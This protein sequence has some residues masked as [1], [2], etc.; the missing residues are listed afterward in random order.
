M[1]WIAF[2]LGLIIGCSLGVLLAGICA[3]AH[4]EIDEIERWAKIQ[5]E[6]GV[7]DENV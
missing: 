2:S 5:R 7:E 4:D 6:M 1:F 3:C